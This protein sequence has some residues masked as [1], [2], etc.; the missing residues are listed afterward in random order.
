MVL[1]FAGGLAALNPSDAL[2]GGGS[3]GGESTGTGDADTGGTGDDADTGSTGD[4]GGDADSGGEGCGNCSSSA[5]QIG[6][7]EAPAD[8]ANV[9]ATFTVQTSATPECYCDDCGCSDGAVSQQRL[10][11]DGEPVGQ[12]CFAEMCTWEVSATEG[13][14]TITHEAEYSFDTAT[15]S[16][17]VNVA[18]GASDGGGTAGNEPGTDEGGPATSAGE[19]SGGAQDGGSDSESS[20]GC[21]VASAGDG[22]GLAGLLLLVVGLARRRRR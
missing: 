14:H 16:I 11:L 10:L 1:G 2:A 20:G 4:P 13:A 22:P 6:S 5:T 17:N 3:T 8:G 7:I 9:E 18:A 19:E 21:R 15:A 12:P